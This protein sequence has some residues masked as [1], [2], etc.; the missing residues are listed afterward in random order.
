MKAEAIVSASDMIHWMSDGYQAETQ[1]GGLIALAYNLHSDHIK[2]YG[3]HRIDRDG[4]H[5]GESP[6]WTAIM[7]TV[8]SKTAWVH[9]F[10]QEW[11]QEKRVDWVWYSKSEKTPSVFIEHEND[12]DTIFTKDRVRKLSKRVAKAKGNGD[13]ALAVIITYPYGR[14]TNEKHRDSQRA[15]R[16]KVT[17]AI[18]VLG[19]RLQFDH[20]RFLLIM[21]EHGWTTSMS[22]KYWSGWYWNGKTLEPVS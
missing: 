8:L 15:I 2:A 18:K 1:K 6:E 10:R 4:E 22:R 12:V 5:R 11:E 20:G 13:D 19:P 9:E 17:K 14:D 16:L 21:G 7:G 3:K